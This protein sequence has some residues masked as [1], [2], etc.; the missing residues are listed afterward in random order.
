MFTVNEEGDVVD[1]K[2]SKTSGDLLTDKLIVEGISKMPKWKPAKNSKGEKVKQ[3]FIFNV[4][5]GGC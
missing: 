5:N 2:I 4:G 1:A 3:D